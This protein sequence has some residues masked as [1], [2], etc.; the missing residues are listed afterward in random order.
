MCRMVAAV[1]AAPVVPQQVQM[2]DGAW[3]RAV[4][5]AQGGELAGEVQILTLDGVVKCPQGKLPKARVFAPFTQLKCLSIAHVGLSSLADFPSLPQLERLIL[6]DNRIA[7][8]L[9]HLVCAGLT[10]LR[11]LDL[12]NNKIQA[13][14][15]LKPLAQ[16]KLESLDLYECTVTRSVDYRAKVFGTM[17]SL[18]FLDKTDVTGND[19]PE[20]DEESEDEEDVDDINGHGLEAERD[21][22]EEVEVDSTGVALQEEGDDE[23]E[24][25]EERDDGGE[26]NELEDEEEDE[27]GS[28]QE[29]IVA[30]S[31]RG[32]VHG[33]VKNDHRSDEDVDDEDDNVKVRDVEESEEEAGEEDE[34]DAAVEEEAEDENGIASHLF[35]VN[36]GIGV[37]GQTILEH[38]CISLSSFHVLF[39]CFFLR[40]TSSV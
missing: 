31:G 28:C 40:C 9:E 3:F 19:R 37:S 36:F 15:D 16:F 1:S 5:Q 35:P 22:E 27:S 6:S 23:Q 30:G 21:E 4:E 33:H 29:E 20:S 7:G 14:E 11:E 38:Y 17:K 25:A 18:R 2:E 8:G 26:D 32:V 39:H 12:S 10:S 24:E 13:V 34:E